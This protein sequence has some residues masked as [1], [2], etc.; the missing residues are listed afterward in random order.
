MKEKFSNHFAKYRSLTA[1]ETTAIHESMIIK[2]FAKDDFLIREGQVMNDTYFV[3]QGCV[4]Q[5]KLV[6]GDE[7]T[8]NFFTEEQWIISSGDMSGNEPSAD[9]L[10]CCE[11]TVVSVGNE[12]SARRIFENFPQF[13]S[14]ARAILQDVLFENQKM[15]SAFLTQTPE[16]RYISLQ[17]SRP[18]ILQRVSQYHIASYIGVKPESLSRIRKRLAENRD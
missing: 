7:I 15:L 18:D 17:K 3:L 1:D 12:E 11:D 6:D 9:Y 13:E 8:T 10:V 4:R 5:Y 16:Q 14:I 2:H